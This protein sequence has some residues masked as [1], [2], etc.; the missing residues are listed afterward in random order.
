MMRHFSVAYVGFL[1]LHLTS[2]MMKSSLRYNRQITALSA[3]SVQLGPNIQSAASKDLGVGTWIA[4]LS[5]SSHESDLP[6]AVEVVG[7]KLVAWKNPK[8]L[9]WSVMKDACSH[10]LAPLSQGRVDPVTGCIE[11]P[12][13]GQQFDT[14]GACTKI[15]QCPLAT[16]PG[17]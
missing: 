3:S 4:I 17:Q 11:C 6:I 5:K 7:E 12:Y 15:P 9:E 10:R 13:H 2:G 1:V 14:S 8:T 16:I